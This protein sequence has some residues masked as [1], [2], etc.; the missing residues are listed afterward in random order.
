[1]EWSPRNRH[2]PA[3]KVRDERWMTT[4]K[5]ARKPKPVDDDEDDLGG[6][7]LLHV[8]TDRY[9]ASPSLATSTAL[10]EYTRQQ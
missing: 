9:L 6:E 5:Q 8:L 1:M 10:R 7:L 2:R 3:P 4:C